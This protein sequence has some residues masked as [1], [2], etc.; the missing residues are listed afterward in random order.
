MPGMSKL[1]AVNVCLAAINEYRIG[2]L[3]T[4][5]T[6]IA[7]EA[8]RY[9]DRSTAY[10]CSIGWPCNTQRARQYTPNAA[11]Q[12]NLTGTTVL[13]IKAAGPSQHRNLVIRSNMVYDADNGSFTLGTDPI[14]IDVSEQLDF[15]DL[16]PFL[17]EQVSQH[18]A[19]MFAR[20]QN[21]NQLSDQYLAQELGL[22]DQMQLR[23][24]IWPTGPMAGSQGQQ[25]QQ[26]GG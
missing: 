19:Q 23:Q 24:T 17:R 12:I 6:S 11:Q 20:R 2:S 8:E 4:G 13:K 3:E 26:G 5:T 21:G 15:D 14:F 25:Q 1:D 18:A 9:V 16:D 7:A 22:T 10:F